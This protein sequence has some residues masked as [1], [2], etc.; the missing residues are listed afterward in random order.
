MGIYSL[1]YTFGTGV[2][3]VAGGVLSDSF[4]PPAIWYGGA[5]TALLS[6]VGFW[7]MLHTEA[8][9]P[10]S[11]TIAKPLKDAPTIS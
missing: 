4:G 5:F 7:W 10:A 11:E 3:P 8:S 6:A 1:T 2:G 9:A